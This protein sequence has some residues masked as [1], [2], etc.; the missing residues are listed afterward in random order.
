MIRL[1]L[2]TIQHYAGVTQ[3]CYSCGERNNTFALLMRNPPA[4]IHKD[5]NYKRIFPDAKTIFET[6]R[7]ARE[8]YPEDREYMA[9]ELV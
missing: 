5:V 4:R 1:V 8:I 3:E 6:R 7:M 2:S 9:F